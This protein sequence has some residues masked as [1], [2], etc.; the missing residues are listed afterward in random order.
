[1]AK[2]RSRAK[3]TA[4]QTV[5]KASELARGLRARVSQLA[6]SLS[7]TAE[8][9]E[10]IFFP[11][12]AELHGIYWKVPIHGWIFEPEGDSTWRRV[13]INKVSDRLKLVEGD[14]GHHLLKQRARYF[15]ADNERR[16]K[17]GVVLGDVQVV[18]G[19]SKPNGHFYATAYVPKW[20]VQGGVIRFYS[21]AEDGRYFNGEANLVEPTGISVISDIDDT[22]K[23]SHVANKR[24]LTRKSFTENYQPVPGIAALYQ[25]WA[26]QGAA[27]HYCSGSPWQMYPALAPFMQASGFP[28]GSYHLRTFRF[29]DTSIRNLFASPLVYKLPQLLELCTRFAMRKFILVGDCTEKDAELYAELYRRYPEQ[30]AMIL[31]RHPDYEDVTDEHVAQALADV[32][33]EKWRVFKSVD[34]LTEFKDLTQ[35][36]D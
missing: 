2:L 4:Q 22:I 3:L 34:E 27:F 28:K 19:N 20:A 1:M 25:E 35:W 8:D 23:I 33:E 10:I 36:D 16:K 21:H 30:I 26:R 5:Y 15:L 14:P 29:M 12:S 18:T 7:R 24:E 31:I 13:L 11:T 9:E 17:V 32:P 6:F